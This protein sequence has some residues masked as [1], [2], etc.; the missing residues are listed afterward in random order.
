[1]ATLEELIA[2]L[3]G[4]GSAPA[5]ENPII[6]GYWGGSPNYD[7]RWGRRSDDWQPIPGQM[8]AY[9][10]GAEFGP[11]NN[12]ELIPQLQAQMAAAGL[13]NPDNT[14]FGI[15]DDT[16]VTGY[17]NV[18]ELANR[19]GM[20]AS[21]ALQFLMQNP[22][23][24]GAARSGR[25]GGG[26]GV[27]RRIRLT[28]AND[29]QAVANEVAPRTIGR[30]FTDAELK[31]FVASY[32]SAERGETAGDPSVAAE[33]VAAEVAPTEASARDLVDVYQGFLK[34]VTGG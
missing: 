22:T 9:E 33:N 29:L 4:A 6:G 3:E 31:K 21:S 7:S 19:Y 23:V 12:P 11:M 30:R 15:W 27:S 5:D 13:I 8:Y 25:G 20:S 14:R 32:H 28:N 1:M 17:R 24:A 18:L 16:S 34:M 2:G 26:G 10:T